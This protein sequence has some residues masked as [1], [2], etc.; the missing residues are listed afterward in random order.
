MDK[1]TQHFNRIAQDYNSYKKKNKYYYDN[2][3]ELLRSLI[4]E[5]KK[6]L[7]IGCGTGD[8]LASVNPRR[9]YGMDVSNEMIKI[10][11]RK[12][13]S[14][15]RLIFSI[16][17]PE[18]EKFDCIFMSDVIEHLKRPEIIFRKVS[19]LMSKKTIFVNTM[20]NPIWEPILIISEKLGLKMP[21][22]LHKRVSFGKVKELCE[23]AGMRIIK[24]DFKLLFPIY[25]PFI[26]GYAN[27]NLEKVF[28]KYAFI[29]YFKIGKK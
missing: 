14:N 18:K 4:P 23:M 15:R 20:A 17:L 16:T 6:V 24:H 8:L 19:H 13:A 7:E 21:E 12:H 5:D 29:E 25:I 10:A 2:L 3:K 28:K 1:V 27:Q 22:G 9:G 26:T 11:K